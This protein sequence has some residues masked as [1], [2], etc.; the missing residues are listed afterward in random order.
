MTPPVAEALAELRWIALAPL[1]AVALGTWV[2]RRRRDLRRAALRDLDGAARD[3]D[4]SA[5][6]VVL[7]VNVAALLRRVALA[8][9]DTR[10]VASLH[11][12][13]W[14]EF[15]DSTG[16][17]DGVG[18]AIEHALCAGP[19]FDDATADGR[20]WIDAAREWIRRNT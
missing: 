7:A 5:D 10:L 13:R 15:L 3:F 1:V 17:P 18:A 12:T 8:S 11:G 6:H 14:V 9:Y 2:V 19:A 20:H 4:H 16:M